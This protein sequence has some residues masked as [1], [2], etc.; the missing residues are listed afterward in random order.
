[1][2][3]Q[4]AWNGVRFLSR[5]TIELMT[6]SHAGDLYQAPGQG[7]GLVVWSYHGSFR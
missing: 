6:D 3:N 1:M 5:K 2:L 4:G 7:F